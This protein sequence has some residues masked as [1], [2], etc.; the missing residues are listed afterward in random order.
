MYILFL[1]C[2]VGLTVELHFQFGAPVSLFRTLYI[3]ALVGRYSLRASGC[4][5][6]G[7]RGASVGRVDHELASCRWS[8]QT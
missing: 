8:R 3:V 7:L 6:T 4:D 1:G 5:L 2:A